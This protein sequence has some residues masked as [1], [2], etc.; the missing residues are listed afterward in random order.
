MRLAEWLRMGLRVYQCPGEDKC[1]HDHHGQ[2][3]LQGS[4]LEMIHGFRLMTVAGTYTITD[5]C[6]KE[7][8]ERDPLK[9]RPTGRHL[10]PFTG[11]T[12][13]TGIP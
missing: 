2:H 13:V 12:Y 5:C 11:E 9:S 1:H 10:S 8:L 3:A 6:L 4:A 7:D